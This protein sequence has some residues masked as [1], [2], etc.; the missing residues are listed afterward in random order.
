M[1]DRYKV[2]EAFKESCKSNIG[3]NRYGRI[4][5]IEDD[6]DIVGENYNGQ[7]VDFTI[8]DNCY[9][10]DRFLGTT[11]SKKIKVNILNPNNTINL[12]DKT[13]Q[14]FVGIEING[15]LEEI[16]YGTYT[17]E[18]P[19]DKEVQQKTSFT[20]YDYMIKFNA[21]YVH[22]N[23]IVY[24]IKLSDFLVNLCNQVGLEL[25]SKDFVNA[26]YMILGN[27]F[28][29]NEDCKTVLSNIAQLAGGFAKIGR[30]NKVYICSLKKLPKLLRVKD[31]HN[32][33]VKDL[34]ILPVY[35]LST[36]KENTEENLDGNNYFDDFSKNQQWGDVNS[37][38]LSVSDIEGENTARTDE[39]S[40]AKN[41]LTEI[42]IENN[43][44]LINEE[45]RNKI[46]EPLW[47]SL[48]GLHY[49]PF[50]T[51]YYGY[52]YLDSGDAIA[53]E[54]TQDI[55]YISYVFNHTFTFNGAFTGNIDTSAM[56]KTQTA[57]KNTQEAK[58]KFKRVERQINKINGEIT[59]IIEFEDETTQ[60]LTEHKQTM[61]TIQDT[62]KNTKEELKEEI[63]QSSDDINK[64]LTENYWTKTE[65]D[66]QIT[67]KADSITSEVNKSISTAKQEAIDS[68]NTNTDN[69]LEEYTTTV[70][71]LIEQKSDSILESVS[72]DYAT[73]TELGD[74]N[75]TLTASLEL[76]VDTKNLISEISASADVINLKAGRLIIDSGNFQLDKDGNITATGGTIGGF[77]LGKNIFTSDLILTKTFTSA[78]FERVQEIMMGRIV[79][80]SDDYEKYDLDNSGVIN[81]TD[82][83]IV[84]RIINGI[85][86]GKG[87]LTLNT[88]R[89]K[90]AITIINDN[91]NTSVK[92]GYFGS[93]INNLQTQGLRAQVFETNT[94]AVYSSDATDRPI[95][96][97]MQMRS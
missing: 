80:T 7:L 93:Y 23:T 60:K 76:K 79:P 49:L 53:V 59:D 20:G 86:T 14:V 83:A 19:D 65:T 57:Y 77:T 61:D 44:F 33:S 9:V 4:H 26:D 52:P 21:P 87:K 70:N 40:I 92:I 66:S 88:D 50:K 27:P 32:M 54:D 13:I 63:K 90:D 89:L 72:V 91:G 5:V 6:I 30:D 41:G 97:I 84:N 12:E 68:A 1:N 62:V 11:V 16:P 78:D 45:E 18:K 35:M 69:K 2:S 31:V 75:K 73:K 17:I 74:V 95:A 51:K 36:Y 8:E 29:N 64:N 25:G 24:P 48:K 38:V 55:Q 37:L 81:V 43:Y 39:E 15:K 3:L 28:T 96:S 94:L 42:T 82:L 85:E 47:E 10:N 58:S 46:I 34:H 67:Q 22:D 56:T 71:S